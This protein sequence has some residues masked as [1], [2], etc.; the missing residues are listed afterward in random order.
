MLEA[1]LGSTVGMATPILLAA[2][3]EMKNLWAEAG[4]DPANFRAS[5]EVGGC[6]LREGE[7]Y[8]SPRVRAIAG[9]SAVMLLHDF[10]ERDR[11]GATHG[12][13]PAPLAGPLEAYR[14]HYEGFAPDDAR[15]IANHRGH[16]MFLKPADEA[17][18]T[19]DLIRNFSWTATKPELVERIRALK[20]AGFEDFVVQ[21][22]DHIPGMLDD[23]ADVFAAV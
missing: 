23:W 18:C 3:G 4:R 16:L 21:V 14:K 20:D 13:V 7:P 17:V 6:V 19:A 8:D 22:R 15:Y 10:V 2:L 11:F 9:P 5:A 12:P 1:F